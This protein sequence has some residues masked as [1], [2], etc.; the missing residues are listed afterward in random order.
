MNTKT[1]SKGEAVRFGWA[2]AKKNILFFIELFAILMGI[3]VGLSLLSAV[4]TPGFG[5]IAAVS[6][7]GI[8]ALIVFQA[9][10]V[11]AG[12]LF[13]LGTVRITLDFVDTQRAHIRDLFLQY[14]LLWRYFMASLLYN[15]I[16]FV[17]FLLL[18][19]PGIIWA[20]KFQFYSFALVDEN[21]GVLDS[22]RRSAALTQG[23]KWN[24]LL[25]WLVLALVVIAGFLTLG[26]G[27]LWAVPT[28]MVARAFVFR[29][30][31]KQTVPKEARV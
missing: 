20:L 29:T 31:V 22:F 21:A 11:V 7:V 2:I 16:V 15:L 6:A 23:V 26:I 28:I 27:L 3:T 18:V 17:G 12:I 10:A 5:D 25:L 1:F 8:G 30:L 13:E 4:V 14:R 19:V 24:L 9:L